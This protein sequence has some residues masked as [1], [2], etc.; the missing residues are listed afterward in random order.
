MRRLSDKTPVVAVILLVVAVAVGL[1]LWYADVRQQVQTQQALEQTREAFERFERERKPAAD[2]PRSPADLPA[3]ANGSVTPVANG[4]RDGTT[5]ADALTAR[6]NAAKSAT[7]TEIYIL[8]VALLLTALVALA[9]AGS[10]YR[11]VRREQKERM[12]NRHVA[13]ESEEERAQVF[14]TSDVTIIDAEAVETV[15]DGTPVYAHEAVRPTP[16]ATD[17]LAWLE[18]APYAVVV[19]TPDGDIERVNRTFTDLTDYGADELPS[20]Q[21]YFSRV[22]RVAPDQLQGAIAALRDRYARNERAPFE[23]TA[24]TRAGEPRHWL[25]NSALLDD[26]GM[27]RWLL[28]ATDITDRAR[29]EHAAAERALT[30]QR[31]AEEAVAVFE[32]IPAAVAIFDRDLRFVQVNGCLAALTGLAVADHAGKP[33]AKLLPQLATQLAP[34]LDRTLQTGKEQHAEI[35]V[36]TPLQ[37]KSDRRWA[38]ACAPLH[39]AGGKAT[40]LALIADDVT[41]RHQ[42]ESQ[43]RDNEAGL[44]AILEHLPAPVCV[45]D[46]QGR[47]VYANPA[48]EHFVQAAPG[49]LKGRMDHEVLSWESAD[50]L[51]EHDDDAL[52]ADQ[53]IDGRG[54][55]RLGDRVLAYTAAKAALRDAHGRAYAV[56]AVYG[57]ET[58]RAED[59][60]GAKRDAARYRAIFDTSPQPLLVDRDNRLARV[61]AAGLRLLGARDEAQLA[62]RSILEFIQPVAQK[63]F[64]ESLQRC[65]RRKADPRPL[66]AKVLKLDGTTLDAEIEMALY[67]TAD[68][69]A[70][71]IVVR[72]VTERRRTEEALRA[73]ESRLRQATEDGPALIRIADTEG[74]A[75]YWNAQ[76]QRT[77]GLAPDRGLGRRW[78][79]AV[80]DDDRG[81]V[82]AAL[83]ALHTQ[84][85]PLQL[86]YRLQSRDG[87]HRWMLDQLMPRMD[88]AGVA[89][90]HVSCLVDI[91]ERKRAEQAWQVSAERGRNV[92]EHAPAALWTQQ[93][94]CL[95][96]NAALRALLGLVDD[97]ADWTARIHP[98]DQRTATE[99]QA[100]SMESPRPVHTILRVRD[101]TGEYRHMSAT[102]GEVPG[103]AGQR[104]RIG[105]LHDV[106]ALRRAERAARDVDQRRNAWLAAL[107]RELRTPLAP[108]RHAAE[109][110]KRDGRLDGRSRTAADLVVRESQYLARL[111]QDVTAYSRALERTPEVIPTPCDVGDLVHEALAQA[112]PQLEARGLTVQL[113]IPTGLALVEVDRALTVQMFARLLDHAAQASDVDGAAILAASEDEASCQLE[114][115]VKVVSTGLSSGAYTDEDNL[116]LAMVN[117]W[118]AALDGRLEVT[119]DAGQL[120]FRVNLPRHAGV[121]EDSDAARRQHRVLVVDADAD[122]AS[123]LQLFLES[124]DHDVRIA[125]DAASAASI[126]RSFRPDA[127]LIDGEL[128]PASR[129]T[130][131][132]ALRAQRETA[133]AV[134]WCMGTPEDEADSDEDGD[135][136]RRVNKPVEPD[137]LRELR[138][139]TAA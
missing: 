49:Q 74:K 52:A 135:Y 19:A 69:K 29:A 88:D 91:D 121:D 95:E 37:P 68:D 109:A 4:A 98:D 73:A 55:V 134:I 133:D 15:A 137:L 8:L 23:C 18:H 28:L 106:T 46:V 92:I 39:D 87:R 1:G 12:E 77:T 113:T 38:A 11:L 21:T 3:G 116:V 90:G 103:S 17:A 104:I 59:E 34:L 111:L 26:G 120:A 70:V 44:R 128:P 99:W 125:N 118:L 86:E 53:S 32:R 131:T 45:K 108:L 102:L 31:T 42:T 14:R 13:R 75:T 130:L 5:P 112:R 97:D 119:H 94:G 33:V 127:I 48:Y 6:E 25:V 36:R 132:R 110:L 93:G 105:T 71:Q 60:R 58:A 67:E 126:A 61:N 65:L 76:W 35:T 54:E 24:W 117:H 123:G 16:H 72:D 122:A 80:H 30:A 139:V 96:G 64:Q 115:R 57:D 81:T 114:V 2:A 124:E 43:L 27:P 79:E 56:C 10:S 7:S 51:R 50:R 40:R 129:A 101:A 85:D 83:D 20:L 136:D 84:R 78:L 62:G 100:R 138:E 89:L 9:L 22:R 41:D 82:A 107:G 63:A 66:A 47:Y